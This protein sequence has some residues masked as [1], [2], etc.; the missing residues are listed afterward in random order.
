MTPREAKL[1]PAILSDL[2]RYDPESGKLYWKERPVS[3]FEG[4]SYPAERR[5]KSWNSRCANKEAFGHMGNH[6]YKE[7]AIFNHLF[8]AHRVI[9]AL[10][11]G[12]WPEGDIDHRNGDKLDNRDGNLRDVSTSI[13]CRNSAMKS[14]NSS[15]LTG[16]SYR[17]D[18]GHWRARVMVNG[19]E[20]HLGNF[21]S[22]Q[23]AYDAR[24]KVNPA[25]G[26]SERHGT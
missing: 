15:G 19:K 21:S 3:M 7:G 12:A 14:V 16:V 5:Q 10:V 22:A 25:L 9:W 26:F 17:K 2:L 8:L 11:H 24:L 18:R 13:N 6:G 4:G 20:T 23:D 1:D